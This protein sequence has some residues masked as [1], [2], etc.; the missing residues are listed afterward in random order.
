VE[1]HGGWAIAACSTPSHENVAFGWAG[2][3]GVDYEFK[4]A[5][6][7]MFSWFVQDCVIN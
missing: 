1:F 7:G 2:G 4:H 6:A 3:R 5:N